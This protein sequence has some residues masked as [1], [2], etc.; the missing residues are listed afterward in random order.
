MLYVNQ[1]YILFASIIILEILAIVPS[2]FADTSQVSIIP[3]SGPGKF[4]A[5]TITCFTPSILNIS[6]GDTVIWTNNDNVDHNVVNGMPYAPQ[7]G[8]IFDSGTIAP[9]KTYSFTFYNAGTYK[10]SDKIDRWMVGEVDVRPIQSS[11]VVP[12]FGPITALV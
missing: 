5:D 12:E 9:G 6:P 3:G 1:Y 2:S 11:S 8:A 4:C 10:Y 7:R